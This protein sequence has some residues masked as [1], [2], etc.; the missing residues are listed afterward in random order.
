MYEVF[1]KL[2]LAIAMLIISSTWWHIGQ[3]N[4]LTP[5][6]LY[7][8]ISLFTWLAVTTLRFS[9][10]FYRNC[11]RKKDRTQAVTV[12][13]PDIFHI[14][15]KVARPWR[16]RAGQYVYL[17]IPRVRRWGQ[18]QS[19]PFMISSWS[20][21]PLQ[22]D[23]SKEYE[24]NT[25]YDTILLL[26]MPRDG[27][28][29]GLEAN[30]DHIPLDEKGNMPLMDPRSIYISGGS[31][32][33]KA[34]IEGPYGRELDLSQ[35]GTVF[36][37]A[38]GIGIAAQLPYLKQLVDDLRTW[39]SKTRRVALFWEIE[40]ERHVY[41]VTYL[42]NEILDDDSGNVLPLPQSTVDCANNTF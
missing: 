25:G 33:M 32:K 8:L 4:P 23:A 1:A 26:A 27:F 19:H 28:T 9:N 41:W 22:D 11:S 12:A 3:R 16:F 34:L 20:K 35:Y 40:A 14:Y 2:H 21:N 42:M 10:L 38:T 37:I 15:V 36:L 31:Q 24:E 6:T 18:L 7:L 13:L 39:D 5:P 29:A 17:T 30:A